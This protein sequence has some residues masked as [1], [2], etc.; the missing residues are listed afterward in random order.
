MIVSNFPISLDDVHLT[1]EQLRVVNHD[2]QP[3]EQVKV[4]ALAGEK[5]EAGWEGRVVNH[6]LRPGEQVKVVA[7]AG[8]KQGGRGGLRTTT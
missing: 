3:G 4:V 5:Q 7:L 6:N 8:E 2:L 1:A